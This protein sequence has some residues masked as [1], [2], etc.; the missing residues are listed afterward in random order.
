MAETHSLILKSDSRQIKQSSKDLDG[1]SKSAGG[2]EKA[3]GKTTASM[4]ALGLT[5]L[6]A[7][8][9]VYAVQ[10]A[11][12]AVISSGFAFNKQI[13]EAKAGLVA[14]SVATQ[15]KAISVTERFAKANIEATRTLVE[16]QKINTQTPH[17]LDQ[18]NKI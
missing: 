4:K 14:L 1:L 17:T 7:V 18:T 8:G 13:E 16:L 6:G 15:D 10:K 3:T 5:A 2:T 12:N 9:G 11:L